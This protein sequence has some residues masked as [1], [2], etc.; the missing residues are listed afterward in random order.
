VPVDLLVGVLILSALVNLALVVW[1]SQADH[2]T[3]RWPRH[4]KGVMEA[5][6]PRAPSPE[7]PTVRRRTLYVAEHPPWPTIASS[8]PQGPGRH[9]SRPPLAETPPP[10]L[11]ELL[12]KPA[13]IAPH[14]DGFGLTP[15][16]DGG[17]GHARPS[18][19]PGSDGGQAILARLP[20]HHK[21][22]GLAAGVGPA[23]DSPRVLEGPTAW[24]R[25]LEIEN[26]RLLRYRRPITI[27]LADV[28]GLR[29]LAE[30]LGEEPVQ[31]LLP[32]IA[33]TFIRETRTTDWIAR[34]GEGRFRALLPETDEIQAI[35]YVERVRT[36]CELW[37]ASAA[38]LRLAIGWSSP[39]GSSDLE[40]AIRRAE[41]RMHADRQMAGR[42]H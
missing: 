1:A 23:G 5:P 13:G 24:S 35:N 37:L 7:I 41:E 36:G 12:W 6:R 14:A 30:L 4:L 28:E 18:A 25:I 21:G 2:V 3:L 42:F 32:V 16:G 19:E 33:D 8:A 10:D 15:S 34:V 9:P 22:M 27:V 38:P 39:A 17:D 11:A 31:R 29:H 40:F 26:A 20:Q